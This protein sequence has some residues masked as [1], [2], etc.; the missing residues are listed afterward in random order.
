MAGDEGGEAAE[1]LASRLAPLLDCPLCLKRL[2]EPATTPCGHTYCRRCL[3]LA[4]AHCTRCPLCRA[5]CFGGA[6]I[7]VN[8]TLERIVELVLPWEDGEERRDAAPGGVDEALPAYALLVDGAVQ[9]CL[10]SGR[11]RAVPLTPPC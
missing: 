10:I 2:A 1:A 11:A 9:A 7:A 5:T 8:K 4:L 6:D 3:Q